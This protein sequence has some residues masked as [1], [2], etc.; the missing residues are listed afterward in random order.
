LPLFT[1]ALTQM[2]AGDKY[3]F[4]QFDTITDLY[5]GGLSASTHLVIE[6]RLLVIILRKFN[7]SLYLFLYK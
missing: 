7:I 1:M 4:R 2:G 3:S 5:T 6:N